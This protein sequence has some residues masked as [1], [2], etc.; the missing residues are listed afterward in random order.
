MHAS[1]AA[2]AWGQ[3]ISLQETKQRSESF[4]Q[5]QVEATRV[6]HNADANQYGYITFTDEKA[7]ENNNENDK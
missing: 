2:S 6:A 4:L 3:T 7:N 5:K 1:T